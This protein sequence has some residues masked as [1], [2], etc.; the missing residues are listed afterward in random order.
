[1]INRR[2]FIFLSASLLFSKNLFA[3][4]TTVFSKKPL[5]TNIAMNGDLDDDL[6][7]VKSTPGINTMTH[8]FQMHNPKEN[9]NYRGVN[10]KSENIYGVIEFNDNISLNKN[11]MLSL[12]VANEREE[13]YDLPK[14]RARTHFKA[15]PLY[16]DNKILIPS[17]IPE[18]NDVP[19]YPVW[20]GN[21]EGY[22]D[23]TKPKD[24]NYYKLWENAVCGGGFIF[25]TKGKVE[26]KLF[27]EENGLMFTFE[28]T[29]SN[30]PKNL[31]SNEVK[32]EDFSRHLL[33]EVDGGVYSETNNNVLNSFVMRYA[34]TKAIITKDGKTFTVDFPYPLPYPNRLYAMSL[35]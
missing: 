7:I 21:D 12:F 18:K 2:N 23:I 27:N 1:M 17:L 20:F 4:T 29:V 30:E 15:V 31:L 10:V 26:I 22:C 24:Y 13:M 25:P 32:Y 8:C 33:A 5:T 3:N 9:F 14:L 19:N 28:E 11:E 34:I 16:V 35:R 6:F